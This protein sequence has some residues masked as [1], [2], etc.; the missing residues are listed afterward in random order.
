MILHCDKS[1][2]SCFVDINECESVALNTCEQT[3]VNT[4]GS[5][6]CSCVEGFIL[7]NGVCKGKFNTEAF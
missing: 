5:F 3:C 4:I 7:T 2:V 1:F 6:S